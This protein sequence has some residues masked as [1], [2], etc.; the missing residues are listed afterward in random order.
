MEWHSLWNIPELTWFVILSCHAY[1][2]CYF[3]S[4]ETAQCSW[5]YGAT[6]AEIPMNLTIFWFSVY[7]RRENPSVRSICFAFTEFIEVGC[8]NKHQHEYHTYQHRMLNACIR[9]ACLMCTNNET[10]Q[11]L[12]FAAWWSENQSSK[13]VA[14]RGETTFLEIPSEMWNSF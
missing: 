12:Y 13:Y 14:Y 10:L 11:S 2:F 6:S 5:Y 9:V 4:E 8:Y 3:S 1:T 7:W